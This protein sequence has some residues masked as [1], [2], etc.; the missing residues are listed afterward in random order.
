MFV[1][2]MQAF[3]SLIVNASALFISLY[4]PPS[5]LKATDYIGMSIW[6]TGFVIEAVSDY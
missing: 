2:M 4:S 5:G 1:F 6:L 3:F